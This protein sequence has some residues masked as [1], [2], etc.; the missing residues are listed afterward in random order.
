MAVEDL[1]V[2]AVLD[3]SSLVAAASAVH[4]SRRL[5]CAFPADAPSAKE[6]QKGQE[7]LST[8]MAALGPDGPGLVAVTGVPHYERLREELLPRAR[9]LALMPRPDQIAVLKVLSLLSD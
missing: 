5:C 9:D 4:Q 1:E 6:V 3:F 7:V 2:A 8:L